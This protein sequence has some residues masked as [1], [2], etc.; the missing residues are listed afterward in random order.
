[1][2]NFQQTNSEVLSQTSPNISRQY[3]PHNSANILISIFL[4]V[5]RRCI[6]NFLWERGKSLVRNVY[7]PGVFS[8]LK[9]IQSPFKVFN[10]DGIIFKFS[11]HHTFPYL[12]QW[13]GNDVKCDPNFI[14]GMD[15]WVLLRSRSRFGGTGSIFFEREM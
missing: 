5:L 8:I 7:F 15:H 2:Y 11:Q 12:H 10:L 4:D 6:F 13:S 9:L 1:M 3:I 14:I